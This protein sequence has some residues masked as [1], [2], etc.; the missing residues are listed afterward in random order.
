MI[1]CHATEAGEVQEQLIEGKNESQRRIART[2]EV[3]PVHVVHIH[4]RD[5]F[6]TVG[7]RGAPAEAAPCCIA[8]LRRVSRVVLEQRVHELSGDI[9]HGGS[10]RGCIARE[11]FLDA[12]EVF[13]ATAALFHRTE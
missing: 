3:C 1:L 7:L 11:P 8:V 5:G 4:V 6:H 12:R 9:R 10:S 13:E 2:G